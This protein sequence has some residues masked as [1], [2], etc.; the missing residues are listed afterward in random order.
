MNT[1][2]AGL[3]LPKTLFLI[4]DQIS[5]ESG[6]NYIDPSQIFKGS[7]S[8]GSRLF[9]HVARGSIVSKL[10]PFFSRIAF[11]FL[12]FFP[13]LFLSPPLLSSQEAWLITQCLCVCVSLSPTRILGCP[14]YRVSFRD[15]WFPFQE[16][17][18]CGCVDRLFTSRFGLTCS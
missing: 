15:S 13:L 11:F 14:W 17:Q 9:F 5:L 16:S 10:E 3:T 18:R 12:C 2:P 6:W 7:P 1:P 4:P 8:P